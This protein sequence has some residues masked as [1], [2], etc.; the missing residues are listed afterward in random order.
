[1]KTNRDKRF[2]FHAVK[3]TNYLFFLPRM[4][5]FSHWPNTKIES[6]KLTFMFASKQMRQRENFYLFCL[7]G[8]NSS[9]CYF[10]TNL[11][12]LK[13]LLHSVF[14]LPM[15]NC[16]KKGFKKLSIVILMFLH[17]ATR[18]AQWFWLCALLLLPT[19]F[20]HFLCYSRYEK[21]SLKL[22]RAG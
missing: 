21:K 5:N 12:V 9:I 6:F 7:R 10:H 17:T 22:R 13:L 2:I 8:K 15:F 14:S 16:T 18:A 1:M 20:V 11:I 4:Q 3:T 19:A